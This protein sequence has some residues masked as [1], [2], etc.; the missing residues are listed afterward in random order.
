MTPLIFLAEERVEA[1]LEHL[2]RHLR[3]VHQLG[4]SRQAG[5]REVLGLLKELVRGVEVGARAPG[6]P[7]L[8]TPVERDREREE[9]VRP[10]HLEHARRQRIGA[11]GLVEV[12]PERVLAVDLRLE[13]SQRFEGLVVIEGL[14]HHPRQLAAVGPVCRQKVLHHLGRPAQRAEDADALAGLDHPSIEG[15]DPLKAIRHAAQPPPT[16]VLTPG[17]GLVPSSR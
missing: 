12:A 6:E 10:R 3:R 14:G 13:L 4:I 7:I 16:E 2:L 9:L 15:G 11:R 17:S 5:I 8:R 1:R